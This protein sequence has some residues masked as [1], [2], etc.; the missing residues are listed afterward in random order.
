MVGWWGVPFDVD[1]G[2]PVSLYVWDET[3]AALVEGGEVGCEGTDGC[4]VEVVEG[5]GEGWEI[6]GGGGGGGGGGRGT[7]VWVC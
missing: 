6:G 2:G 7:I 5:G 1:V 4:G 3:F